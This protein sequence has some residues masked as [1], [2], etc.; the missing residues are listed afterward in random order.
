[1]K[2]DGVGEAHIWLPVWGKLRGGSPMYV[3]MYA[4]MHVC[5]YVYVYAYV[6]MYVCMSLCMYDDVIY[7]GIYW[8][9]MFF[10]KKM[11]V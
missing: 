8:F 3:Y 9:Y 1:V 7:I 4:C 11:F 10:I 2:G 6:F 5:V